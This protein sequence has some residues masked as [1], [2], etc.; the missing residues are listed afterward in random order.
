MKLYRVAGRLSCLLPTGL[1]AV[2]TPPAPID[3]KA[4]LS[5]AYFQ[6]NLGSLYAHLRQL[7]C[8]FQACQQGPDKGIGATSYSGEM[9]HKVSTMR[10]MN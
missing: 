9:R 1:N 4:G 6:G 8:T 5:Y 3:R 10:V 7:I 2:L